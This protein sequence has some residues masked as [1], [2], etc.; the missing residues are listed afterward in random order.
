MTVT[1]RPITVANLDALLALDVAAH[2][3]GF[4]ASVAK[5]IAQAHF[6]PDIAWFRAVYADEEPAGFV[7]LALEPGK[8]PYL[9]RFLVDA[10][11]QG[12]GVGRLALERV[13]EEVRRLAPGATELRLSHVPGEGD[14]GPFYAR[15]G[16]D[17]TGEVEDG[18][19]IMRRPL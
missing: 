8:P 1:L 5:S 7:M 10:R 3:R 15:L 2:Q 19:R 12:R 11:F 4:V 16:F 14:P 9:W 6:Y 17:Y 18:E 13:V